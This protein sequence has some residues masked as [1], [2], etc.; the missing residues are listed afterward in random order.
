MRYLVKITGLCLAS[1]IV[2]GMALTAT[3]SA[4]PTWKQCVETNEAEPPTR[5]EDSKCSKASATGKWQWKELTTTEAVT[6][7]GSLKLTDKK[8]SLTGEKPAVVECFGT[9]TGTI[10]PGKYDRIITITA[11]KCRNIERCIELTEPKAEAVNLPWQTELFETEGKIRDKVISEV[12]GKEPGWKVTCSGFSDTCETVT[13]TAMNN[14]QATGFVEAI[15]DAGSAKANCSRGGAG[16]GEVEGK[17]LNKSVAGHA[18]K[19][20]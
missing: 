6:A 5:W 14:I 17:V 9:S 3:A 18:I 20:S 11:T 10:G 12:A 13:T 2:M 15:F 4:V 16:Q 7:E 19:V 8:G 1:V